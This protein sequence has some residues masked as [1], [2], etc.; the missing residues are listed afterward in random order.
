MYE[1]MHLLIH[2]KR[3]DIPIFTSVYVNMSAFLCCWEIERP[4]F[5]S[6]N[7]CTLHANLCAYQNEKKI[8][9]SFCCFMY[10]SL[11]N[12]RDLFLN[13]MIYGLNKNFYFSKKWNVISEKFSIEKLDNDQFYI[14]NFIKKQFFMENLINDQFFL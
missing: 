5:V 4:F 11:K 1:Y 14:E 2:T 12:V 10:E 13:E 9:C 6:N 8:I 7:F 3:N